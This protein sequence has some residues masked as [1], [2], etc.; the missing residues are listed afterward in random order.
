M[1]SPNNYNNE[2]GS[3]IIK[4]REKLLKAEKLSQNHQFDEAIEIYEEVLKIGGFFEYTCLR[5]LYSCYQ[6]QNNTKKTIEVVKRIINSCE[7]NDIP[8]LSFW[9]NE[10]K[11]NEKKIKRDEKKLKRQQEEWKKMK[12]I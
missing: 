4:L 3:T 7:E 12:P 6:N 11:L 2:H 10:L 1:S 8:R 5:G 9:K